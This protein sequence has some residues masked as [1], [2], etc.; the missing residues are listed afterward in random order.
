MD[1]G[2]QRAI[3]AVLDMERGRKQWSRRELGRRA[4][5]SGATMDRVFLAQ[6]DM[7]VRQ[8]GQ[9]A[10]ALGLTPSDVVA[11]AEES[12]PPSLTGE[13][14]LARLNRLL[15]NPSDDSEL[16]ARIGALSR[17]VT[18]SAQ[19]TARLTREVTDTR[20]QELLKRVIEL[21]AEEA[22]RAAE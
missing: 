2:L 14:E 19:D 22:R 6:R 15:A 1:R 9:L 17:I 18:L 21:Q 7:D 3:V 5:I 4:G 8:L 20:R 16:R 11:R 13:P 12:A 10:R